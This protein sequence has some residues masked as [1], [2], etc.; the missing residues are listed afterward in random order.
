MSRPKARRVNERGGN[1]DRQAVG[2]QF[3]P[4]HLTGRQHYPNN[5]EHFSYRQRFGN[6]DRFSNRAHLGNR[7]HLRYR[8]YTNK[9]YRL[10]QNVNIRIEMTH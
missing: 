4:S 6:R 5:R 3:I 9:S 7:E 2:D 8:T 10:T 1:R